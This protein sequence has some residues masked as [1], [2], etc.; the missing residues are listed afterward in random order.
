MINSLRPSYA[1]LHQ[2]TELVPSLIQITACRLL[3]DNPLS[4]PM[5]AYSQS[6]LKEHISINFFW[7]SKYFFKKI[8]LKMSSA[9]WRSFCL[10]LN[11]LRKPYTQP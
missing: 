8:H 2:Q 7:S 9:K 3:S 1:Y 10:G 6:D 5:M 4:E 11:V